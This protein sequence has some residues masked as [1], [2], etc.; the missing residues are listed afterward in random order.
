MAMTIAEKILARAAGR[1]SVQPGEFIWAH[2]DQTNA[3]AGELR[4]L[5]ELGIK[6][7][8]A[9]DTVWATSDHYAPATD[10]HYANQDNLLRKYVR[11][12]GITNF[13]EYGRHGIAHQLYGEHGAML[14]GMLSAMSD[15]HSTSGGVFNCFATPIGSETAFVLATGQLWLQVPETIRIELTGSL[16]PLCYGKDV[17]LT[18]LKEIGSEA[19]IYRAFEFG[20]PG[21]RSLTVASR[22]TLSNMG[23]ELGAKAAICEYD[24]ILRTY[25]A[26]RTQRS[27]QPVS[28]D[29]GCR[30]VA[31]HIIDLDDLEP[32]VACPHD[33]TN[34][35]PAVEVE[36][37]N[38]KV[39]QVFLGSCTNGR[40]ED[41]EIAARILRGRQ[42]HPDVRM[43]VSPA[44]QAV[45][46]EAGARG[47]LQ[48]LA[49]AGALVSHSTCG[50]CFGGH[51]GVLGDGDVCM[52]SSNRN[53]RGRMGS[54]EASVYLGN[55][56]T[57]AAA[58]VAGRIVDP[59]SVMQEA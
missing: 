49:D 39:S 12:Y 25:L 8:A 2:V 30:Y 43:I 14:P 44:S 36:G 5:D 27:Y 11:Q 37:W 56:A 19:G 51:L 58:A 17:V 26:K 52:S 22:W 6:Q 31:Q 3:G 20:G 40:L 42:V 46:R 45:W 50:P 15:S 59:R 18:V 35:H 28:P 32:M 38:V 47:L 7:L 29:P 21:L 4:L 10:E 9:P 34:V 23:I 55:A 13:F 53:Y 57:V 41:L 33:P 16:G 1:Q 48:T 24:E 54:A